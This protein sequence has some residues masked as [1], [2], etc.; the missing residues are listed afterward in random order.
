M[1]IEGTTTKARG[2]KTMG[3]PQFAINV[4][5]AWTS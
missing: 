1:L 4:R 3:S 2:V 5:S